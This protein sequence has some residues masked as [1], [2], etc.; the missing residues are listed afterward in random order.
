MS[1]TRQT[2]FTKAIENRD[3]SKLTSNIFTLNVLDLDSSDFSKSRD[4]PTNYINA[5]KK[6]L[7]KYDIIFDMQT[8]FTRGRRAWLEN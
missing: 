6:N 8:Y 2:Y 7:G 5:I 1:S 4:F 3:A